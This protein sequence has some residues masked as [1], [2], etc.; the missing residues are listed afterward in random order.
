MVAAAGAGRVAG[1]G[2]GGGLAA[3]GDGLATDGG[4]VAAGGGGA[5]VHCTTTAPTVAATASVAIRRASIGD[6][7]SPLDLI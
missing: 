1:G 3:D 6:E 4:D 7:P 2:A 5:D